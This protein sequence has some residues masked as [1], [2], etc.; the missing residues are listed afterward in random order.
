MGKDEKA[1]SR[2]LAPLLL[3]YSPL[4]ELL[5]SSEK[6]PCRIDLEILD[7]GKEPG[8]LEITLTH[9]CPLCVEVTLVYAVGGTE[10][11]HTA[12]QFVAIHKNL[13][14][15]EEPLL[16]VDGLLSV[17]ASLTHSPLKALTCSKRSDAF[18]LESASESSSNAN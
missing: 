1:R 7:K 2:K 13:Q 11:S 18:T 3:L 12:G 8:N 17:C 15:V 6:E 5:S 9:V 10:A 14:H 16:A 4:P